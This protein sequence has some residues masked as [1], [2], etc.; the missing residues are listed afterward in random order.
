LAVDREV[1]KQA[2]SLA[3]AW[4]ARIEQ[5][6]YEARRAER[7]YKAVDPDNRVVARTL[8]RDW[9]ER[10]QALEAVERQYGEARCEARVE[11]TVEDRRR[12]RELARDLPAVWN[13]HTTCA[14][15]RKAMM[16]L[17]IEAIAVH[18]VEVPRRSTRIR[19]QWRSGTVTELEISRPGRGQ[20]RTHGPA[21]VQRI[22]E[23]AAAGLHD[24]EIAD[25]LEADGLRTGSDLPWKEDLVRAVRRKN[26]IERVAKDRPRMHALPNQHPDGRYSVP[27]AAARFGVSRAVVRAWIKQGLVVSSRADFGTHRNVCWLHMDDAT[28]ARLGRRRRS[29]REA[30]KAR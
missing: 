15:D 30:R 2:D 22:R 12:I 13:V 11:L 1:E 24:D 25:R 27:G 29:N 19:V 9:E 21:A 10:L 8:E 4:R 23:L 26:R 5:A 18:P 17:V 20:Y 14:A 16:R 3:T 7:R 28:A 6:R